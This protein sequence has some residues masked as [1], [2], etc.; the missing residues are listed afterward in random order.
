MRQI[1]SLHNLHIYNLVWGYIRG[2]NVCTFIA[3][4]MSSG[5][6]IL[7]GENVQTLHINMII[8]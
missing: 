5:P 2:K 8:D 3:V 4:F 1:L 6:Q 7:Q